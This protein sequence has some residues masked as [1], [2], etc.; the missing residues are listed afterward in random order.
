M[1]VS[2]QLGEFA[3]GIGSVFETIWAALTVSQFRPGRRISSDLV[4][5]LL[6]YAHAVGM[7]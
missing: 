4:V 3:N 1:P 5:P 6:H 7:A 2:G